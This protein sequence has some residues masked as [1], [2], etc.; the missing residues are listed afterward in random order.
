V[1]QTWEL[2]KR[3]YHNRLDITYHGRSVAE[4]EALFAD[5]RLA[6]PF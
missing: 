4:A 2:A 3:W 6:G 5:L 1:A